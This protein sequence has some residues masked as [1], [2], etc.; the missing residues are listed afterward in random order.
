MKLNSHKAK[1]LV[2]VSL[3]TLGVVGIGSSQTQPD[4]TGSNKGDSDKSAVTADQQKNE[5]LG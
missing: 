3:A 4:N 1:T 2:T 5:R